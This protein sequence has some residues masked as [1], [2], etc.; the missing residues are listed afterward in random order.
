VTTPARVPARK[1]RRGDLVELELTGL[2]DRGHAVGTFEGHVVRVRG[3]VPGARVSALVR[4]RR[5]DRVEAVLAEVLRPGDDAVEA[6]CQHFGTCGGCSFQNLAY[7][8]QL[9][10]LEQVLAGTLAPLL[11]LLDEAPAIDPIVGCAEP[12]HYRNKMDFTFGTRRWIEPHEPEGAPNGFAL[13]LHVP[14][15]FDRVLDIERCD[16]AFR[17]AAPIVLTARELA[18]A[19]EL[20][21][22]DVRAHR[23]LL[24]HLVLRKGVRTGEIMAD[25]VTTEA[26]AERL[27]PLMREL[28][29]RHPEITTLVQHVNP[30]VALVAGGEE[31]VLHGPG[32]IHEELGGLAFR[33]SAAS[34][35]Q[36]NTVQ[37]EVLLEIVRERVLEAGAAA[38]V[39]DLYC[40]SGLF[41]LA[42]ARASARVTGYELVEE[43]VA[44]ARRNAERN[45]L[46]GVRFVVGDL[47]ETLDPAAW[48]GDPPEV[49]VVDPPRAGLH[50]RVV[51]AL[52]TLAPRRVVY[53]SC[54]PKSA[55]RDL[56][57]LVADGYRVARIQ[58]LDLF[59]HTP[60]LECVFALDRV[61]SRP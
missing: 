31:R 47:A 53:V 16:I 35:F 45:G 60:H 34:F 29:A 42:L 43:A 40:G 23:G 61:A 7:G 28:L 57:P 52:R 6:R 30:G 26:A 9:A 54:N 21:A 51:A 38:H 58:P 50:A 3:G 41:A 10:A 4:R 46:A 48:A 56:P 22:W 13:G 14:G 18:R 11:A 12:W 55:A 59:P 1:P 17:E 19:H 44:D 37:A 8:A 27:A 2:D 25:L 32:V 5:R 36:T 39:L 20:D 33:I 24:R 49:C 15:R